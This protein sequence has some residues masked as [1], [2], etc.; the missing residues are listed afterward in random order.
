MV[1]MCGIH[2]RVC[3]YVYV[4]DVGGSGLVFIGD[5][6]WAVCDIF[7]QYFLD[8]INCLISVCIDGDMEWG[9][10]W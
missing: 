5:F 10:G 7:L 9:E 1:S 4:Y 8:L 6:E 3:V 2:V